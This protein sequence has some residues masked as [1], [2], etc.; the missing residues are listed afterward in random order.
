MTTIG[1]KK[2]QWEAEAVE[3]LL[4]RFPE[5][6]ETFETTSG[7]PIDRLTRPPKMIQLT[8]KN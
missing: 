4:N 2:K 1:D 7:I 5:R 3:P 6:K 8:K